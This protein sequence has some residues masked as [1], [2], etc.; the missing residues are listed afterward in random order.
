MLM[1]KCPYILLHC[2]VQCASMKNCTANLDSME[3]SKFTNSQEYL[4]PGIQKFRIPQ[5]ELGEL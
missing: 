1:N 2:T 4:S 5:K 3:F